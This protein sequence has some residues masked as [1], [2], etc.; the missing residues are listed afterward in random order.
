MPDSCSY[1]EALAFS[2]WGMILQLL[3][4]GLP[5]EVV[6]DLR[7]KDIEEYASTDPIPYMQDTEATIIVSFRSTK[8][9]VAE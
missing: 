5:W 6:N 3:K 1:E 2:H 9:R 7:E 8:D 4:L